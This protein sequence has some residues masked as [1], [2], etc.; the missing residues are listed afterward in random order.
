MYASGVVIS[1][2]MGEGTATGGCRMK[3]VELGSH[4]APPS[5]RFCRLRYSLA[6]TYRPAA[7]IAG[8]LC[9]S[10]PAS[11]VIC[12]SSSACCLDECTMLF[13]VLAPFCLLF[14]I[15]TWFLLP[16]EQPACSAELSSAGGESSSVS[17]WLVLLYSDGS[18]SCAKT[19][20]YP[21]RG[22]LKLSRPRSQAT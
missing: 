3:Q 2:G 21:A 17:T 10:Y 16:Y 19:T 7:S 20:S 8:D 6:C 5:I 15:R 12:S 1:A 11:L 22:R 4:I 13:G 18:S 9:A 14:R